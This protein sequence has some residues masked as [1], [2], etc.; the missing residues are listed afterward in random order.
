MTDRLALVSEFAEYDASDGDC[1]LRMKAPR[2]YIVGDAHSGQP[3]KFLQIVLH[4]SG[5][6]AP[7][8]VGFA[9]TLKGIFE[10]SDATAHCQYLISGL[11]LPSAGELYGLQ[12]C[13]RLI[14]ISISIAFL[15]DMA[16]E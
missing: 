5:N 8:V 10:G 13:L 4:T 7:S 1:H 16:V 6:P 11:A 15:W 14:D 12:E 9:E 3:T 2:T